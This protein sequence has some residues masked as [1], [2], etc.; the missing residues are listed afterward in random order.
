MHLRNSVFERGFSPLLPAESASQVT[1]RHLPHNIWTGEAMNESSA[2]A[3]API[4]QPLDN[5]LGG[6]SARSDAAR[7]L[8]ILVLFACV[9][10]VSWARAIAMPIAVA[11]LLAFMLRPA[12]RRLR[13]YKIP[14][15]VSALGLLLLILALA[16]A[17]TGTVIQP[18]SGWIET[19]P[20]QLAQVEAKLK[21][22][23]GQWHSLS[24]TTE[25]VQQLAGMDA[26]QAPLEVSIQQSQLSTNLEFVSS[27]ADWL[28]TVVVV[29]VLTFFL[30]T[31]GDRLLNQIL[32]TLPRIRDKR[33]TVEL[34]Y[35]VERGITRYL[36][37]VTAINV[38]LGICTTI[39]MWLVGM[40]NPIMWGVVTALL[41]YI[42]FFGPIMTS[43]AI[44]LGSLLAF[45]SP[46]YALLAPALFIALATVEGNFITPM[47]LGHSI[48]LNPIL[49]FVALMFWTWLWGI[50]G[51]VLAVPMLAVLKLATE[52]FESTQPVSRVLS[53]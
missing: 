15:T 34:V 28:G 29:L 32:T 9:G 16:V 39:L 38:S 40:P 19:A 5:L 49:V 17:G 14:D 44:A 11:I 20:Q 2:A 6:D 24:E 45:E 8:W 46:G 36:L 1:D 47:V 3:A 31:S 51:A 48:S 23:R 52:S 25:K 21:S 27:T 33:R 13:K 42:P 10:I 4:P 18:I 22:L 26:A 30:L 41:N 50:G 35:E 43:V 37:T 12:V 7:P 53:A